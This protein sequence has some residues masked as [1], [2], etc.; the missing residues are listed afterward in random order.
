[1]TL[2][3][4]ITFHGASRSGK[5]TA[6]KLAEQELI[7]Q[8]IP[9]ICIDFAD[10]LRAATCALLGVTPE[11]LQDS[12]YR[13]NPHPLLGGKTVVSLMQQLGTEFIREKFNDN[14]FIELMEDKI[15][16]F[17]RSLP[18]SE[19]AAVVL[20]GDCRFNNELKCLY[21]LVDVQV[22]HYL[23]ERPDAVWS[24][25]RSD[26]MNY[27]WIM[28]GQPPECISTKPD[29]NTQH[30]FNFG[31]IGTYKQQVLGLIRDLCLQPT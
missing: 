19:A 29:V 23:V 5:T 16:A 4:I 11:K 22:I 31:S 30:V 21:D 28:K 3:T 18:S 27:E 14:F 1:M 13:K 7:A 9:V 25:H 15:E 17:T 6:V 10:P 12:N 2:L 8:G 24:G 26:K 20:V